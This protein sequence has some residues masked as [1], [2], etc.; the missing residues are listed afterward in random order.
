MKT[1]YQPLTL[2]PELS[3]L[4]ASLATLEPRTLPGSCEAVKSDA[5]MRMFEIGPPLTGEKLIET[6]VKTGDQEITLSL[7]EYVKSARLV[8]GLYGA[9]IGI[10]AGALLGVGLMLLIAKQPVREIHYVPQFFATELTETHGTA[11]P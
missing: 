2:P 11:F 10:V 8:A 7:R 6:I 3:A 9:A 4:E 5:L 1:Q